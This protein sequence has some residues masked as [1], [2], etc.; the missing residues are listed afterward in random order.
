[1]KKF[2]YE[3]ETYLRFWTLVATFYITAL[4]F[5]IWSELKFDFDYVITVCFIALWLNKED[6]KRK[7]E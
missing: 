1:M 5:G 6:N 4:I 2:L 7:Q 3:N